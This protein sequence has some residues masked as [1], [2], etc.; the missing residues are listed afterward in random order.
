MLPVTVPEM[1][2][3]PPREPLDVVSVRLPRDLLTRLDAL[4]KRLRLPRSELIVS[5]VGQLVTAA[6]GGQADREEPLGLV[7]RPNPY[8]GR[9]PR[10]RAR[11]R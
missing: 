6:E 10:K 2:L 4:A 9:R 7:A 11:N 5:A 1:T 3:P 8:T